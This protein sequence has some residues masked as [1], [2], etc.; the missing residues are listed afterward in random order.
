V[1]PLRGTGEAALSC[2]GDEVLQLAQFHELLAP[3]RRIKNS[4]GMIKS[5]RLS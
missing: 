5:S 1:E 4:D 2:D 3:I